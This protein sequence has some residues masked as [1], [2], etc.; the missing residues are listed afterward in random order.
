MKIRKLHKGIIW[1][2]EGYHKGYPIK[3]QKV[4]EGSGVIKKWGIT[5]VL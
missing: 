2:W 1:K 5:K 3:L 4:L